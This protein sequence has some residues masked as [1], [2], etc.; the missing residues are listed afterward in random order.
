M[1]II[2]VVSRIRKI[3]TRNSA[4]PKFRDSLSF[5]RAYFPGMAKEVTPLGGK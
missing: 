3:N 5:H 4:F 1:K 2:L